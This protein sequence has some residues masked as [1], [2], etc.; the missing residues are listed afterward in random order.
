MGFFDVFALVVLVVLLTVAVGG[1]TALAVIPGR[2]AV[3]R[4]HPRAEAV[5]VCAWCGFLTGGLLLPLAWIWAYAEGQSPASPSA[6]ST[7]AAE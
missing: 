1:Y 3:R 5:N 7:G 4:N 6:E 2:V